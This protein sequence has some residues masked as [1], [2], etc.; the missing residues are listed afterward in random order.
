MTLNEQLERLTFEDVEPAFF[1]SDYFPLPGPPG[2]VHATQDGAIRAKVHLR[3]GAILVEQVGKGSRAEK[4]AK[5]VAKLFA[6]A[7]GEGDAKGDLWTIFV[8]GE[9]QPLLAFAS[10]EEEAIRRWRRQT[11]SQVPRGEIIAEPET[12]NRAKATVS[13]ARL[14]YHCWV[15]ERRRPRKVAGWFTDVRKDAVTEVKRRVRALGTEGGVES[16]DA[17]HP[18]EVTYAMVGGRLKETA[19]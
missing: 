2:V 13:G 1:H 4:H 9:A 16:Q 3:D 8:R 11:H 18:F 19:F 5:N 7:K 6:K 10:D 12:S 15:V 14:R 17:R